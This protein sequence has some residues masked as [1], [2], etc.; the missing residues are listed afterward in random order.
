MATL[1]EP[2]P[3]W[4]RD[5]RF[6]LTMAVAIAITIGHRLF[7]APRDGPLQ[8]RR[9]A[10]DPRACSGLFRLGGVVPAPDIFV[11]R[12]VMGLHRTLGW[13]GAGWMS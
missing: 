1:A 5:D 10:A 12:G 7:A 9:A 3:G 13:I 6:F 11:Y 8:L 2:L 4:G